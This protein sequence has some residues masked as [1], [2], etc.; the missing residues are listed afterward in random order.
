[1][2]DAKIST[3]TMV[4]EAT[5]AQALFLDTS[6][7]VAATVEAHPSYV[8]AAEFV[9]DAVARAAVLY[10][11]PQV[12]REFL[13]VLTRQPVSGRTFTVDEAHSALSVWMAGCQIL[14]ET[15]AVLLECLR[16][17]REYAV[18]GKQVHDCNVAATMSVHGVST[19][20]TRNPSDFKRYKNEISVVAV[21]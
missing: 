10:L 19:L 7:I 3:T 6:L 18:Q 14:E 11:S 12:C 16:L 8:T 1:M 9:D 4:G 20:A 21:F 15:E 17:S 5:P 2:S 13:V